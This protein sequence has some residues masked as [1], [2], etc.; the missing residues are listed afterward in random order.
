M[1]KKNIKFMCGILGNVN[2][3]ISIAMK[4]LMMIHFQ[5]MIFPIVFK[6][7]IKSLKNYMKNIIVMILK[8]SFES[9][10]IQSIQIEK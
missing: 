7:S 3:M 6:S 1:N 2:K 8:N 9:Y 10:K 5:R 4:I